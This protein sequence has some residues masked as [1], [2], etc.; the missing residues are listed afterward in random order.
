MVYKEALVPGAE[1]S[2]RVIAGIDIG[3]TSISLAVIDTCSGKTV[4]TL[5]IPNS[6]ALA[7]AENGSFRMQDPLH[8]ADKVLSLAD[9][10]YSS[11]S[12]LQSIGLT[13]Q[14][15]GILYLDET[16]AA[17]SPL[18][19]WQDGRGTLSFKDGLSYCQYLSRET[20]WELSSG[21]G[22]VTHFYNY[23]NRLVPPSAVCFCSIMDYIG[24]ILTGRKSPLL[25]S[26]CAESFGLFDAEKGTFACHAVSAL[27]ECRFYWPEVAKEDAVLGYFKGVPVAIAIGDNQASVF[28]S[29][30]DEDSDILLNIGTGSQISACINSLRKTDGLD[31]RSHVFGRY[32]QN[33]SALCGGRAYSVLEKFF[34]SYINSFTSQNFE[35]QYELMNGLAQKAL[36]NNDRLKVS[37]KFCGT[38]KDSNI[39][40]VISNISED[41]FTPENLILG[42][43]QGMVEELYDFYE[44]MPGR[45]IKRVVASGNGIRK[46]PVLR[47]LIENKFAVPVC[48]PKSEEEAA[49]GCAI[50]AGVVCQIITVAQAKNFIT[51]M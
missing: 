34:R 26:S 5:T 7:C 11:Y 9:S 8:I 39:R 2:D 23:I 21:Y 50:Y 24:V 36:Y 43:L 31:C 10:V 42:V 15:H 29:L 35:S 45:S 27:K 3:T 47:L 6:S 19:T 44:L 18:Y 32:L 4:E 17:V 14:M 46:N 16:G 51:Y 22:S 49:F 37:T 12:G 25:H 20:G 41:N 48:V 40:G 28:G 1:N 38:R 13:G 33:G 30:K